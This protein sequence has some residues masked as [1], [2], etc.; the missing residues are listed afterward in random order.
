[1]NE[2][3]KHKWIDETVEVDDEFNFDGRLHLYC[4]QNA[5]EIFLN[6]DDAEA[7]ANYF[8]YILV[9]NKI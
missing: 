1:M 8:G 9:D 2:I 7:I 5:G 6:E 3:T 4:G